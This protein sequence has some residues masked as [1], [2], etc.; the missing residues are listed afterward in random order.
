MNKNSKLD[1]ILVALQEAGVEG[2]K[3][4]EL[5]IN[6]ESKGNTWLIKHRLNKRLKDRKGIVIKAGVWYLHEYY[7]EMTRLEFKDLIHRIELREISTRNN[8]ITL[9]SVSI[10]GILLVVFSF[11]SYHVG[12]PDTLQACGAIF[13][14]RFE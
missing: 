12:R 13:G 3:E 4:I 6:W 1:H 8:Y 10:F 5:L 2:V 7:W 14:E 11:L 9:A